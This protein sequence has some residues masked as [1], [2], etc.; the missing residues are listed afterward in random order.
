MKS[1]FLG[2]HKLNIF[3]LDA[4]FPITCLLCQKKDIWLCDNCV[5]EFPLLSFQLCPYC[6]KEITQNGFACDKC[7]K[8]QL[9]LDALICATEYQKISKLVHLFKYNFV[10]SLSLPLG[11]IITKALL[12]NNIFLPDFIVPIPVHKHKLKWRGF[13]QAELLAQAVSKN[14]TKKVFIPVRTDLVFRQKKT[15]PQ[16]TIKTYQ[17]RLN[18][19]HNAFALAPEVNNIIAGKNILLIDDIATTGATLFEC[20]K[21]LKSA[22]AKEIYGAIIARQKL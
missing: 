17:E 2:L 3:F 19:I 9:T 7:R 15:N 18:N 20:A 12:K 13:N 6:E 11:K 4:L 8:S 5:E 21:I 14:L 1:L 22:G 10:F 16:M